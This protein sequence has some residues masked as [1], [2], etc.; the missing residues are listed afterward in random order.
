MRH[1]LL[2]AS[3]VFAATV[4][5][6]TVHPRAQQPA[7]PQPPAQ[8]AAPGQQAAPQQAPQ[9]LGTELGFGLFQQRCLGCH[10]NPAVEKA[11]PPS[12]LR[13]LPP[14]KILEALT[15][16][17]MKVQGKSLS[18]A[19]KRRVSE[20]I[21]GRLL[22]TA[23]SGDAAE[24]PNQCVRNQPLSD[25]A[26]GPEWNGW[27]VDA[28]NARSQVEGS[29][30]LLADHVPNLKLKWAFGYPGGISAWG[31][32]TVASGRVFVGSDTGYVYSLDADSGC[33]YWSYKTK[34]GIRAA[35]SVGPVAGAGTAKY[36]VYVGDVKANVYAL[37]AQT[38]K[39]IWTAHVDD[40]FTSRVTAGPTL[41]EHRLYVPVS[42]WEEFS[43][44]TLDY[45]CCTFRGAVVALDADTG[46]QIWKTYTLD[47]PKPVRKN[48]KGVQLSAPAGAAVWNSPTIDP[49]R[50][51]V[52]FGTGDAETAP[53]PKTS[54]A[55]MAVDMD[56]GKVLWSYQVV[57]NDSFL[58]G[59]NGENKTDN[60]PVTQGPDLD[61]PMS[62]IL[63][64]LPNGTRVLVTGT[65]T[66]DVVAL[67]P[68]KGG[69]LVWKVN[70]AERPRT[71]MFWGGAADDTNAYFGLSSGSMVAVNLATGEKAWLKRLAPEG[72]RTSNGVSVSL[73]P[74]VA[75]VGGT[76]GRL[77]AVWAKNGLEIWT[78]DTNKKF[79]TVNKVPASGG[80][81]GAAG[82]VIAGG[83]LFVGS[84]YGVFAG[85]PGN[86]LLAFSAE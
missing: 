47:D 7:A 31:Q 16:G 28:T 41:Y 11:P 36:A 53:A 74:G 50:R 13:Q 70:V 22:G 45:P 26:A 64:T 40:H 25:P 77:H 12:T 5:L 27:G 60:C 51:A 21:S 24:M 84:G 14:E 49:L 15:T 48:S 18:D 34:A 66:G 46:K 33:V 62:P 57:E 10:G 8:A 17:V 29:A 68:D 1:Y 76:D 82:P 78:Y 39:E 2:L 6:T 83:M 79:D 61:I 54:D 30:L 80:S 20:S 55:I 32:P 35:T 38:G 52:Y 69:A 67:D 75:F 19:E 59:C 85:P 56:S 63:K 72:S 86:V 23:A 4:L 42:S 37:D 71:G 44:R 9:Q 3:S 58:V 81:I 43:A 73:I 65:K